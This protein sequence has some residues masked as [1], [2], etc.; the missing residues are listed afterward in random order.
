M[1]FIVCQLKAVPLI[2]N[3][4]LN[5]I[6]RISKT[7]FFKKWKQGNIIQLMTWFGISNSEK[8]VTKASKGK[9]KSTADPAGGDILGKLFF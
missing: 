2:E 6:L 4:A 7:G 8:N 9:K 5:A 3:N 1:L